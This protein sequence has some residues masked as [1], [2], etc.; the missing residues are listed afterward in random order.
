MLNRLYHQ[1][2]QVLTHDTDTDTRIGPFIAIVKYL[3][4]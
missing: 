3:A 1:K 4:I 2:L